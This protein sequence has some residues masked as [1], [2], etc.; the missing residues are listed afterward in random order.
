MLILVSNVGSSSYKYQIIDIATEQTLTKGVVERIGNPPSIF[1]HS[2]PGKPDLKGEINAPNHNAA[3]AH[4]IKLFL[5]QE[6]GVLKDLSE[7]AGVGFKTIFAKGITRS[8]LVTEDVIKAL[9]EYIPVAPVHN[10]PYIASIRAFQEVLPGK[11]LVA[12]FETWFHESIPDYAY[13]FG[14]PRE[15][16]KKYSLRRYGFHGAS[17]R[18]ISE[19]T[20]QLLGVPAEKLKIISCHL[21]GSSSLCAIKYG[22]SIDT[23][24]GF[25]T[26]WGI[27]QGTRVGDFDPFAVLYIMEKEGLTAD[28]MRNILTKNSGVLGISEVSGDMRDVEEAAAKGNDNARLALDTFH[29]G[30]KKYIGAYVAALGGV[31]A[32]A[33]T[34]GI[35]EKGPESREAICDGLEFMGI[36]LDPQ[37]N[38]KPRSE[39]IISADDSRVK[40]LVILANEEIIVARET[41][42]VIEQEKR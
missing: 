20:S 17:H 16:V 22:K 6:Y 11:P 14:V 39:R 21:G 19:R 3:V 23:S 12:V 18:Y 31:D 24:M 7:L 38:F 37:K 27:I 8:A 9:E 28:E 40:V 30:V 42:R 29:Y 41:A 36:K 4:V 26:Q 25:S 15:W 32:I 35:G 2:V 34:G 5:S 13:E 10:P 1:T 33:F